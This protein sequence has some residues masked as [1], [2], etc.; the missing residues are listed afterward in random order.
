MIHPI[1][2][3]WQ[4]PLLLTMAYTWVLQYW[5]EKFIPPAHLDYH[6]LAMSIMELMHRVK[7]HV[8][9]YKQDVLW[10]LGRI[11]PET[12]DWDPA[13]PQ[14]HSITQPTTTNIG[15]M[16]SNSSE[17]QEAHGATPSLFRPPPKE[18]IPSVEPIALPTVDDVGHTPPGLGNPLSGGDATVLSTKP[19]MEDWPTGQ[20]TSPIEVLT[21]LVPK[22][23]SV[24][25]LP[26]PSSHP[27]RL[28]RKDGT[29]WLWLL[30]WGGWIW[31]Q[32]ES[33]SGTWWPPQLEDQP[34]EIPKWQQFSL[35][36]LKGRM[37]L[38][39]RVPLWRNL[40]GKMQ[41]KNTNKGHYQPP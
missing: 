14:G 23:A 10:G 13:V 6:P 41:S 12:V 9:F 30:W 25:K 29:C 37:A 2:D 31:K 11:A 24:V 16:E 4:Q 28:K 38:V 32:S 5:V 7:E 33:S 1:R 8:I 3:V 40:Q 18:E 34:S 15:G 20:D 36:L 17:A 22:T 26:A 39:T 21:Q 27:T 19:E 35:D